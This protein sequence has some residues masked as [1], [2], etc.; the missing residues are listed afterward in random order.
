MSD[1]STRAVIPPDGVDAGVP[2]HFGDP[3]R[4]QRLLE[5]GSAVVHLPVAV[6][7]VS[8]SDRLGWLD[9]LSSQRL[10]DSAP[11]A[12]AELLLLDVHGRIEHAAAVVD[13]GERSFLLTE[14]AA[15]PA[16]AGYLDS[17]RF[18]LAVSVGLREDLAV[19]GGVDRGR[20]AA[21]LTGPDAVLAPLAI[22]RDPW[23]GVVDGGTRY[24]LL[25]ADDAAHPG[26][27]LAFAQAIVPALDVPAALQR[28]AA[29]GVTGAGMLAWEALR[30]AAWRPR[31]GREVDDKTL[32]HELDWLRTAVHLTKGCY[33]GQEGVARTFNLGRTPRRLVLL[34]LDGSDH[35]IPE[36]GAPVALAGADRAEIAPNTKPVGRVTSVARHYELGPIALAVLKRTVPL[37]APLVVAGPA[38]AIAAAQEP[39]VGADG[40]G[41]GR[42][43]GHGEL[44]PGLRRRD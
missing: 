25:P 4:E 28:L 12:S 29:A 42:P 8:G 40:F 5:A 39:I 13:D 18:M 21:A 23:P 44:T 30:V 6:V 1:F 34:H 10:R 37:D 17:M 38:G 14:A 19:L 26:R 43:A 33:R 22:W 32:P 16:L 27:A 11:G 41:E 35:L 36:P 20:F 31:L 24:S 7:E 9:T 3:L 15:A 2:A